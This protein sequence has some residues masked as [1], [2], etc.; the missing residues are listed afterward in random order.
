MS[1]IIL[2]SNNCSGNTKIVNDIVNTQKRLAPN[3]FLSFLTFG[4]KAQ[5]H[6]SRQMVSKV[7]EKIH[8]PDD[9]SIAVYDCLV[10]ILNS[11]LKFRQAILSIS[12]IFIIL[13]T[14]EDTCSKNINP[15]ILC[16]QV[17]IVQA[18]GCKLIYLAPTKELFKLGRAIGC[19]TCVLYD[20]E[21]TDEIPEVIEGILCRPIEVSNID[22][23]E[24]KM[25]V[26]KL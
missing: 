24:K 18:S 11:C 16:L 2:V 1:E 5:N 21:H 7:E 25:E 19:D 17:R 13:L 8:V 9:E 26:M 20:T 3:S 12:P 6:F 10:A 15:K 22:M 23:L 14:K 4:K